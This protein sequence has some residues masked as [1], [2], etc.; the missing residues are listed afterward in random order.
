MKPKKTRKQA[1]P[2]DPWAPPEPKG[3]VYQWN[4]VA[5]ND[6]PVAKSI[7]EDYREAGWKKVP[8]KRHP[9]FS[10]A[11]YGCLLME[12]P[13]K[14]HDAALKKHY[15]A[16]VAQMNFRSGAQKQFSAILWNA[17]YVMTDYGWVPERLYRALETILDKGYNAE[18]RYGELRAAWGIE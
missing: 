14:I 4:V 12:R 7:L 17:I 1:P 5:I 11:R 10:V 2:R 18:E 9:K 6:V 13:R 8:A 3:M 15:D 16:A